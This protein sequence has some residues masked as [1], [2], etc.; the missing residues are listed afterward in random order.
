MGWEQNKKAGPGP[1]PLSCLPLHRPFFQDI[2]VIESMLNGFQRILKKIFLGQIWGKRLETRKPGRATLKFQKT[3][4]HESRSILR[5]REITRRASP[6]PKREVT[7][8]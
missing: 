8:K 6:I 3:T 7:P 5:P 2:Q 1:A 4:S